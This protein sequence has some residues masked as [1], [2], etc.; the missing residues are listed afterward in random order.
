MTDSPGINPGSVLHPEYPCSPLGVRLLRP[1]GTSVT[2][3][4][5]MMASRER[6]GCV[7]LGCLLPTS[8]LSLCKMGK[9]NFKNT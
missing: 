2:M 7:Y 1:A 3:I 6:R 9:R 4:K 8:T 5:T